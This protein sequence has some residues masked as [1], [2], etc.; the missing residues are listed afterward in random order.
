MTTTT[1]SSR[2]L[3]RRL[4][5]GA[6]VERWDATLTNHLGTYTQSAALDPHRTI[7]GLPD[8]VPYRYRVRARNDDGWGGWGGFEGAR[9]WVGA[10]H[11][12]PFSGGF[13]LVERQADD[14]DVPLSI[15]QTST[16]ATSLTDR[17][18]VT[19]LFDHLASR[20]E[21]ANRAKVI[22]LY[23][24]YFDRAAEP[25]GLDYWQGRLDSGSAGLGQVSSFFAGSQEFKSTY[26]GT[27]NAQFVE[28]VYQNV[29]FR[30]PDASGFAYWKGRLDQGTVT[31]GNLMVLF[32]ESAEGRA[33]RAAD[34]VVADAYA[35]MIRKQPTDGIVEAYAGHV[36]AGASFGDVAVLFLP[37]N[38][39]PHS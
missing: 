4:A 33:L 3:L 12:R 26:G 19:E 16:W 36:R 15:G 34:V 2:H 31:R 8:D 23:F 32:S 6:Q 38:D 14:F 28:L 20:P 18:E 22:R 37:L 21:R 25:S 13:D 30:D 27:T 1:S 7:T 39:Y 9:V 24:A 29:L 11:L 5:V 10:T 17:H 35:T